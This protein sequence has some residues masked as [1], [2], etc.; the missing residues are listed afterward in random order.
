MLSLNLLFLVQQINNLK[1]SGKLEACL[2]IPCLATSKKQNLVAHGLISGFG[3][4]FLSSLR[5]QGKV[6]NENRLN[7]P[8]ANMAAPARK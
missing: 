5:V 8:I 4:C 7:K 1:R 3:L 6:T 2:T